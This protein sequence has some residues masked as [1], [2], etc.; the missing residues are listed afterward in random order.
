MMN[1]LKKNGIWFTNLFCCSVSHRTS[2]VEE[3]ENL[4]G[5]KKLMTLMMTIEFVIVANK[6]FDLTFYP[7]K[8]FGNYI[9]FH[10]VQQKRVRNSLEQCSNDESDTQARGK[11][12]ILI[13][14]QNVK[15]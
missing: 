4:Q 9:K 1:K 11:H 10:N 2:N 12:L 14:N 6:H 8:H 5:K 7:T 15:R 3:L 13:Y